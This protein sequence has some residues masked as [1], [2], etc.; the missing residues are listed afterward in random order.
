MKKITILY[1]CN[2]TGLGGAAQSL[3]D[4]LQEIRMYVTPIVIIPGKG[5]I[6]NRLE[7]LKIKYYSIPF[8]LAYGMI[9]N[10][11]QEAE[12]RV[13]VNNYEAA[14]QIV[15]IINNENVD[16]VHTNSSVGNVGAIAALMTDK[17]HVWHMRE[18]LEEDFNSEFWNKEL[19]IRLL[20]QA[21]CL[22]A[23]SDCVKHKYMQKY[24]LECIRIYDGMDVNKYK[25]NVIRPNTEQVFLL[26]GKVS[27]EKG[28]FE[29]VKAVEI[30]KS[31]QVDNFKLII[32]GG[33]NQKYI[34]TLKKYIKRNG[35]QQYIKILPFSEELSGLRK[36]ALFSLT[37]SRMEAL[38]RV[39]I[40]A[41]LAGNIVI[42]ADTGGTLELIGEGQNRGYLYRQGDSVDLAK[43]MKKAMEQHKENMACARDAQQFALG[44]F[45]MTCYARKIYEIYDSVINSNGKG[46][47]AN[48]KKEI[49]RDLKAE[50]ELVKDCTS[51]HIDGKGNTNKISRI[52]QFD[53]QWLH[54]RQAGHTLAEYFVRNGIK[55]IAIY[56]MGYLGRNLY[57]EL[58]GSGVEV[59][60][61]I[62]REP[63]NVQDVVPVAALD[64]EWK[65]VDAVV[66]TVVDEEEKL[67]GCIERIHYLKSLGLREILYD[68]DV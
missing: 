22:L 65:P 50:Y 45:D 10:Y 44:Q 67:K 25:N 1:I 6:E 61:V 47:K 3:L 48:E 62:D 15:S 41:M 57:D 52:F 16:L 19:K 9:G 58:E 18:L 11:T 42:G 31:W 63:E 24:K 56:G 7:E 59:L 23:V 4:M 54:I 29:A 33:G 64:S 30:L 36:K 68:F 37:C 8:M 21:D 13:L 2:E 32:V 49:L 66:V 43:I 28:Q 40:E 39:T 12:N 34:W 20:R 26:V 35:L 14:L 17:P 46:N 55:T 60:Y 5:M 38:G 51:T 27:I 53:E